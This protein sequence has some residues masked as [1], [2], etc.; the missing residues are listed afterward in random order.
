MNLQLRL[1]HPIKIVPSTPLN[2]LR[3][4][5]PALNSFPVKN[6]KIDAATEKLH[7]GSSILLHNWGTSIVVTDTSDGLHS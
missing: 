2:D 4:P 5:F 1:T 6:G 7:V 3:H